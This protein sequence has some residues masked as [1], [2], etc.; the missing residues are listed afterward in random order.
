[1]C[2]CYFRKRFNTDPLENWKEEERRKKGKFQKSDSPKGQ[3]A[4]PPPPEGGAGKGVAK[5]VAQCAEGQRRNCG[6]AS[7][8]ESGLLL[9][10]APTC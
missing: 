1:M 8:R 9:L 2:N 3:P 4:T 10:L 7:E 5:T 6:D